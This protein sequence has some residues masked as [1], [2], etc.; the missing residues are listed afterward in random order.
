MSLLKEIIKAMIYKLL[1]VEYAMANTLTKFS[2]ELS[3][4]D[5][6]FITI[7]VKNHHILGLIN[8]ELIELNT[9]EVKNAII[10]VI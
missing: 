1:K 6:E 9:H 2:K 5:D 10:K 3:C 4:L 7:E 8:L